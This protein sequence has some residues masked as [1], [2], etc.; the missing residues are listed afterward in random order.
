MY[1]AYK[2][3]KQGDNMQPWHT[4]KA[5][6]EGNER[7]TDFESDWSSDWFQENERCVYADIWNFLQ[8]CASAEKFGAGFSHVALTVDGKVWQLGA[9]L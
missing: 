1:S 6:A 5:E 3:N 4:Q 2:L 7:V 8:T 9:V